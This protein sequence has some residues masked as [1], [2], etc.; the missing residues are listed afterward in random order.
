MGKNPG[1]MQV[2]GSADPVQAANNLDT[3]TVNI[4]TSAP[5]FGDKAVCIAATPAKGVTN[6]ANVN[7]YGYDT[8][9]KVGYDKI[10][11]T[12]NTKPTVT[13]TKDIGPCPGRESVYPV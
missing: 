10:V 13:F 1:K 3:A 9:G 8:V 6:S 2:P 7:Y 5:D 12:D 4:N 11:I